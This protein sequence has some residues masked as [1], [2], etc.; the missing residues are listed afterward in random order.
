MKKISICS[1]V[2]D[3]DHSLRK[4]CRV[5][6]DAD[7]FVLQAGVKTKLKIKYHNPLEVGA[8]RIANAIGATHRYPG[9]NLVIADLGTATTICVV[10]ADRD[11]LGGLIFPGLRISMEALA[12]KTAKL[13]LVEIVRP[14]SLVARSTVESI[15]SGLYYG[16]VAML[17]DIT[18]RIRSEYFPGQKIR[19]IGTGGFAGNFKDEGVFDEVIPELVHLGLIRATEL[20]APIAHHAD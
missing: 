11:Y 15:Q 4:A 19:A 14:E 20:N 6:F 17:K 10:T 2:P 16:H 3:L 18:A 12:T 8:D 9:E 1:V 13:P 5:Y 7:L